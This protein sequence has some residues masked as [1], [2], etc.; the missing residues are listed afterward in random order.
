MVVTNRIVIR[1]V[2]L[3]SVK[4]YYDFQE[5]IEVYNASCSLGLPVLF[6]SGLDIMS[7]SYLS[8]ENYGRLKA[9]YKA[10]IK[11][12]GLLFSLTTKGGDAID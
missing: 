9:R 12:H 8:E 10:Y 3:N 11:D 1:I 6:I 5:A 2:N 7:P 4:L